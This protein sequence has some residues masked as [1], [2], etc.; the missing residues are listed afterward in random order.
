MTH[1]LFLLMRESPNGTLFL[2]LVLLWI[3]WSLTVNFI[4]RNKANVNCQCDACVDD[5]ELDLDDDIDDDIHGGRFG[6]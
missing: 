2:A 1:D 6:E 4:N 5:K 3:L